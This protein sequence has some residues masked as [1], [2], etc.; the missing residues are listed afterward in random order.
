MMELRHLTNKIF[1]LFRLINRHFQEKCHVLTVM[2]SMESQAHTMIAAMLPYLLWQHA[3]SQLGPKASAFKKWFKPVAWHWV[4]DVFWCPKQRWVHQE[5][6][7]PDAG[8][9]SCQWWCTLLGN[10]CDQNP[11]PKRK[12]P[13]AKEE[14]L[15]DSVSMVKMAVSVKNCP[16]WH[17]KAPQL[18]PLKQK[19]RLALLA[20]LRWWL[21]MS[22][23]SCNSWKWY[24]WCNRK[25]RQS[26][27]ISTN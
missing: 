12:Q 20:T 5:P 3:Q 1:N 25:T 2:K 16:S 24:P 19:I 11:L 26:C 27:L 21:N 10:G 9:S 13:Q 18:W 4:E 8:S 23:Q 17:S 22:L 14:S 15:Y 6:K 7:W